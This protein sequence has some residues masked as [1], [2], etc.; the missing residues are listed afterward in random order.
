VLALGFHD[1]GEVLEAGVA[2]EDGELVADESLAKVRVAVTVGAQR[3]LGVVHV[4]G[5]QAIESDQAVELVEQR[6]ERGRVGHV[7]PG[8]PEMAGIEADA[9]A[10]MAPQPVDERC[11]L[12]ERATD[13]PAG[14]GGVLDQE[15]R[16][17]GTALQHLLDRGSR[18][19]QARLEA[20]PEVRTDV[21]D[22]AVRVDRAGCVDGAAERRNRFLVDHVVR[23]REVA[24]VDRV[25]EGGLDAGVPRPNREAG[26][27]VG[28]VI[29]EAPGPRA[30]DKELEGVRADLVG[31]LRRRLHAARDVAAEEHGPTIVR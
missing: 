1:R 21:E 3:G 6:I 29:R 20:G 8:C 24:E 13:R 17:V 12:L 11:Q 16:L 18:T 23:A 2:E 26:E 25:D 5:S 9:E 31:A 4:K 22:D 28:V 19:L 27:H 10:S 7:V 14:T 30:L 15:P